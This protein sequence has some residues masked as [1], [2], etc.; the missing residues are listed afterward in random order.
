MQLE[1]KLKRKLIFL[2]LLLT[3]TY[4]LVAPSGPVERACASG[5]CD[6]AGSLC[7]Q[8]SEGIYNLCI[9]TGGST[10]NC[11]WQEALNTIRCMNDAG[12][13]LASRK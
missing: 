1:S 12:C 6:L 7:R 2:I 5:D 3:L 8:M 13:P 10:S 4:A 9:A 11:A